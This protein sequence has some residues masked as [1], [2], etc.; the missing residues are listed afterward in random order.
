MY[1]TFVVAR[2]EGVDYGAPSVMVVS[3]PEQELLYN[4]TV[5][6]QMMLPEPTLNIVDLR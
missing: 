3:S 4:T 2:F 6:E 5:Y 1:E